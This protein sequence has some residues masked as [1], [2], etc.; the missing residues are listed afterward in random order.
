MNEPFFEV[1]TPDG[2][3]GHLYNQRLTRGRVRV[4]LLK[5]NGQESIRITYFALSKLIINGRK[6]KIKEGRRT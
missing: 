2:L 6:D 4:F 1:E 5:K 3:I